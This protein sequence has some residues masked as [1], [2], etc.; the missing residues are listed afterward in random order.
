LNSKKVSGTNKIGDVLICGKSAKR[1][2]QG[3]YKK[4]SHRAERLLI[5]IRK[6]Y[7][8]KWNENEERIDEKNAN[9]DE[10]SNTK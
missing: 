5:G 8:W 4:L 6:S 1:L 7:I 3:F 10:N 2:A 9:G